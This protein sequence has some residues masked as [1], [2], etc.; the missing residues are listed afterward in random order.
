MGRGGV[1]PSHFFYEMTF[2]E[3]AAFMRGRERQEQEEW[4]RVRR[5]MWASLVTQTKNVKD[6][7]D[8]MKLP[9][10]DEKVNTDNEP[11]MREIERIR[12]VAKKIKL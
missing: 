7:K 2:Q 3:A 11:D 9:W 6:Y 1:A 10:D 5:I 12:E 8:A 4:E